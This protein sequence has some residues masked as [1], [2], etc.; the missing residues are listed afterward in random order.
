MTMP[1]QAAT[2]LRRGRV[3]SLPRFDFLKRY[4]CLGTVLVLFQLGGG[5]AGVLV[6]VV[7]MQM[8]TIA[9]RRGT[10]TLR[11]GYVCKFLEF[12]NAKYVDSRHYDQTVDGR[13][14]GLYK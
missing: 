9:L 2:E 8:L 13:G 12:K 14:G 1:M 3:W 11:V 5:G 4:A 10:V 6:V 7:D